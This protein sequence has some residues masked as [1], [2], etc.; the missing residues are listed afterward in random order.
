MV[1]LACS[2]INYP[3]ITTKINVE[4]SDLIVYADENLISQV[5][6]NLLKNALQAIGNKQTDG[7]IEIKA[8]CNEKEAVLIEIS[9]NGPIIPSEEAEHIFIPFFT[10]KEGGSGIGLS[11]S[12]QIMRLSGGSI[13]LKSTPAT[14][15]TTFILTFP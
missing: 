12:R 11:I 2:Q 1:K 6:L 3:N 10:T 8:Y 4:P 5:V 7:L 15:R 9:N 14:K 13:A